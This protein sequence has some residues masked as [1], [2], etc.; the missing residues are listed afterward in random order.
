MTD[1]QQI[2]QYSSPS[3]SLR[4]TLDGVTSS[5]R[6]QQFEDYILYV[7]EKEVDDALLKHPALDDLIHRVPDEVLD[8]GPVDTASM[9]DGGLSKED[10]DS[11]EKIQ[12]SLKS[13][14]SGQAIKELS[15]AITHVISVASVISERPEENDSAKVL[16]A[17]GVLALNHLAKNGII[18][19]GP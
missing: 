16:K 9:P 15:D 12:R 11:I 17:K 19:D 4:V 10:K 7:Y 13:N 8:L 3:R 5:M 14:M 2:A 6:D 18:N 1:R